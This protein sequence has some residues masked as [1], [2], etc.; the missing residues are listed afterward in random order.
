[1]EEVSMTQRYYR[2]FIAEVLSERCRAHWGGLQVQSDAGGVVLAGPLPDQAALHGVLNQIRDLGL[3]LVRLES[4]PVTSGAV[5][6]RA[7]RC[8][9][10]RGGRDG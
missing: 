7:G 3:T 1:V 8:R 5:A 9:D 4:A 2:I 10:R 6:P